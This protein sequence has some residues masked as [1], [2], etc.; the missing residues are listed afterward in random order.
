MVS[1]DTTKLVIEIDTRRQ[2]IGYWLAVVSKSDKSIQ[3]TIIIVIDSNKLPFHHSS[4]VYSFLR[5]DYPVPCWKALAEGASQ[6][7]SG[8]SSEVNSTSARCY[9]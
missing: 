5:S 3:Q 7:V 9:C 6:L 8:E 2:I 4:A 1:C